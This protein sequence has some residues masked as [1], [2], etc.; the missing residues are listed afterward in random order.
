MSDVE[1]GRELYAERAWA[2][3]FEF[4]SAVDPARLSAGDLEMLASS[5]WMLGRENAYLDA[6]ESPITPT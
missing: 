4:L 5:A 2:A 1:R 3:A 6:W